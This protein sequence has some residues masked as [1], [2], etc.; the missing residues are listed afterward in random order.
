MSVSEEAVK[1][2]I[3]T[4]VYSKKDGKPI[5]T[6][7]RHPKLNEI[8]ARL[9]NG[10]S[11][12]KIITIYKDV[13][14]GAVKR[15]REKHLNVMLPQRLDSV[16][17]SLSSDKRA[18]EVGDIVNQVRELYRSAREAMDAA[19]TRKN[20]TLSIKA[21]AQAL[22]CLEVYFKSAHTSYKIARENNS[23]GD[24]ME[25]SSA[26]LNALSDFPEAKLKVIEALQ[27]LEVD[28]K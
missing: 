22:R 2:K 12:G 21:N 23:K 19:D 16:K 27:K 7:C 10:E 18:L 5:C 20:Y 1:R 9:M 3:Q 17:M 13:K 6:V 11:P 26:V 25:L 24:V 4:K 28:K 15:H 8:D 14:V